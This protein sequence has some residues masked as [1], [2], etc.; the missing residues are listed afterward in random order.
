MRIEYTSRTGNFN[1]ANLSEESI[2]CHLAVFNELNEK[3][4]HT[5]F[6]PE[7]EADGDSVEDAI[8]L[9]EEAD[10][11]VL[12]SSSQKE[13][14]EM[15]VFLKEN[16]EEIE[17]GNKAWRIAKIKQKIEKLQG[18][19]QTLIGSDKEVEEIPQFKGTREQLNNL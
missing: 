19:L 1:W 2:S 9:L 10:R 6:S 16:Q 15:V 3:I 12:Y 7:Y 8:Y 14:K 17:E 11:K 13:W 4:K 18:E 5:N